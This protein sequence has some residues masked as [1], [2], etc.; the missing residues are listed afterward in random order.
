MARGGLLAA[1]VLL[2]LTAGS[3]RAEGRRSVLVLNSYHKG[4]QW[5]DNIVSALERT[6]ASRPGVKL[7][8]EYLDTKRHDLAE[9]ASRMVP[10]L[11]YRYSR[12]QP[13]VV[14]ACD[15]NALRFLLDHREQLFPGVA[16]VFCGINNYRPYLLEG[17]TN[18][19]GVAEKA[20][21]AGTLA[22]AL[23]LHPHASQVYAISDTTE[24]GRLC[25]EMLDELAERY[26]GKV[27]I[28]HM[29]DWTF[30]DLPGRLKELPTDSIVL[31]TA[32]QQDWAG[33]VVSCGEIAELL[34]GVEGLPVY[35]AWDFLVCGGVL[36]GVV[37]SGTQ[38]GCCAGRMAL[39]ILDG[40]SPDEIPVMVE[41]P[42]VTLF[43]HAAMRSHGLSEADL[44]EGAVL[45]NRQ[46]S[47]WQR[48]R[49]TLLVT[50]GV[51]LVAGGFTAVLLVNILSRRKAQQHLQSNLKFLQTL[52]D[53]IPSPVFSKDA[54]GRYTGCNRGFADIII[55]RPREEIIGR[56]L[57][58]LGSQISVDLPQRYAQQD[59]R[60][61]RR[62]GVQ[63]YDAPVLCADGQRR[64]FEFYKAIFDGDSRHPAG[65][66][67]VMLDVTERTRTAEALAMARDAAEFANRAKSEFVAN[68]SHELRTPMNG[69]LGM[70]ELAL[71]TDLS[72]E[73]QEY[74]AL[75][76]QSGQCM[77]S[78][79]DD[80]LDFS[81]IETGKVQMALETFELRPAIEAVFGTLSL[82]G[83][84]KGLEMI[85]DV[86]A[87]VPEHL[88]GDGGRLRQV[89]MNLL[90]NALRFT[91]KGTVSLRVRLDEC[92]NQQALLHFVV[93]D[94]G[95]GIPPEKIHRIFGAFEQAD[96]TNTRR[97][98]GTGL[99]L[100]IC[101]KL[102]AMM[103]GKIWA[104]SE[105]DVGS[106]FHV[107]LPLKLPPNGQTAM[108]D[109]TVPELAGRKALI[110]EPHDFARQVLMEQ[111]GQ[112]GLEPVGV[113][114]AEGAVRLLAENRQ[115]DQ[116]PPVVI[117]SVT[118]G[119]EAWR[120]V[121]ELRSWPEP[122]AAVVVLLS[123]PDRNA[124]MQRC[125][126]HGVE[127]WIHK[128]TLPGPLGE[129]LGKAAVPRADT[130]AAKPE[131]VETWHAGPLRILVAE[132]N[133]VNRTFLIR[134]LERRGHSVTAVTSGDLAVRAMA[135]PDNFDLVL[136]DLQMPEMS[137]LE[138]AKQIRRRER[139]L[140]GYTP[141]IAV[142]AHATREDREKSLESGM[143]GYVTKPIN[144]QELLCEIARVVPAR[145]PVRAGGEETD[146]SDAPFC[147]A[148]A[149]HR[150]EG[151]TELLGELAQMFVQEYG[152]LVDQIAT[153]IAAGDGETVTRSAHSLKGSVGNFSAK[154][155]FDA[156]LKVEM[157]GREGNIDQAREA[158]VELQQKLQELV[159]VLSRLAEEPAAFCQ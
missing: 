115:T 8:V 98:G 65:I 157:A 36:G 11:K 12:R 124:E 43:D 79:V 151:D 89:L 64:Q 44:P 52:I 156:A 129:A 148:D 92:Q 81:R 153:G 1:V 117:V 2:S 76:R 46:Y 133:A 103:D 24:T 10:L 82:H 42:N 61:I 72:D 94:T 69:V 34:G 125:Q 96:G 78:V 113:P 159:P 45:V 104:T 17:H 71:Q 49:T 56:T 23:K 70:I 101:R 135:N 25:R 114:A 73:Q 88:I 6:F 29:T 147:I 53:T 150:V 30:E 28:V 51:V 37:V 26:A 93:S 111:I 48:H 132:D 95:V 116:A 106:E 33:Q 141:I 7:H 149:L 83:E 66:V 3:L 137:G 109:L 120:L 39:R 146:M 58:E 136:M 90:G 77:L 60:L 32:T 100:T 5:S 105:L 54:D 142:T 121:E 138:A 50:G 27:R 126:Q 16:A 84:A 102:L 35:T 91:E 38:Q 158:F 155:A 15:N 18:I 112:V 75:A 31:C 134:L 67:G 87:H 154:P 19:T 97:Y 74:L 80:I 144:Q 139:A 127:A 22:V 131:Q 40:E 107:T 85:C 128:P 59:A 55:G 20:D 110:V 143:E 62:G 21:L 130:P 123:G 99:G 108:A 14:I 47:F 119:E 122:R 86:P 41:S 9:T 145:A 140:G 63:V 13:D 4:Y 68:M 118:A 152:T 57:F